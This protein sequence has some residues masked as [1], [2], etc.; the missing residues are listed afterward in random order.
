MNNHEYVSEQEWKCQVEIWQ[1]ERFG[2]MC[3]Y[4]ICDECPVTGGNKDDDND[5]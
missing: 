5:E 4:G 3:S 1:C 2:K